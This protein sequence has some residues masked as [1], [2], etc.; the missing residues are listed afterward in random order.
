[1]LD[2]YYCR[3]DHVFQVERGCHDYNINHL[4]SLMFSLVC[5]VFDF[6]TMSVGFNFSFKNDEIK[7]GNFQSSLLKQNVCI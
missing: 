5:G 2:F 7:S 4:L 3:I 1:M 6:L